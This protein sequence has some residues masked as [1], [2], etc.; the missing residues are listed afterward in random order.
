LIL[1][2]ATSALDMETENAIA[3][4]LLEMRGETTIIVIAHRLSTVKNADEVFVLDSGT[5]IANGSFSSLTKSNKL[6]SRYVELAD[7]SS[8]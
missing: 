4:S 8:N 1:D 6:V 5:L 3:T 7:L 2:E